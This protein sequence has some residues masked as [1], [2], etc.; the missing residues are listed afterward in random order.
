M[1]LPTNDNQKQM[2]L[3]ALKHLREARIK[4]GRNDKVAEIDS[5]IEKINKLTFKKNYELSKMQRRYDRLH[6]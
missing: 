6:D 1:K 3:G 4:E 2:V 5:E